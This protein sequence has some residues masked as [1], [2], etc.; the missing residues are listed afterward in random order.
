MLH[1]V[2]NNY[3][4][5][6][7][8]FENLGE[9]SDVRVL[10]HRRRRV[11]AMRRAIKPWVSARAR[12][13][14]CSAYFD[15]DYL[16]QLKAIPSTDDVLFFDI[17]DLKDLL[18]L[19]SFVATE[20][21]WVWLW[22]PVRD[23]LK[24][25]RQA[26]NFEA[27]LRA[28]GFR[29]ATFDPQDARTHGF[30]LLPQVYR[31]VSLTTGAR[32]PVDVFFVGREKNRLAELLRWKALL[33]ERHLSVDFHIVRDRGI[34]HASSELDALVDAP[35]PYAETLRRIANS[36]CILEILQGGQTGLS[37]RSLEALFLGKKLITNNLR[38][39]EEPIYDRDRVFLIGLDDEND[40]LEFLGR[41]TPE[42]SKELREQFEVRSW[43]RNF[44]DSSAAELATTAPGHATRGP[45]A[46]DARPVVHSASAGHGPARGQS[47]SCPPSSIPRQCGQ[48]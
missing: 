47:P 32:Q 29:I 15:P 38:L 18:I 17:D 48:E 14:G 22:N 34:R 31:D 37:V 41:P 26:A 1:I 39:R 42:I 45:M 5:T 23:F 46:G 16:S 21:P 30:C 4:L 28:E 36:R 40:L 13:R 35:M 25:S 3:F 44:R 2:K 24:S 12:P 9:T 33:Q 20:R 43:I 8:I 11:S 6:D 7:F 10:S 27:R 19:R